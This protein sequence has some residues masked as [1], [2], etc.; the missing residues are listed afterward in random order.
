MI[1]LYKIPNLF[2]DYVGLKHHMQDVEKN[3]K[4]LSIHAWLQFLS[5][6][7]LNKAAIKSFMF[8]VCLEQVRLQ[9]KCQQAPES[10]CKRSHVSCFWLQK[11]TLILLR[12]L[13]WRMTADSVLLVTHS[14]SL[15]IPSGTA[16]W[17]RWWGSMF[18]LT[19]GMPPAHIW[20]AAQGSEVIQVISSD[21][22]S[23][24]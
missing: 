18:L 14:S 10:L 22:Q 7:R 17:H 4:Y 16:P 24:W 11:G 23:V 5:N 8:A 2:L 21:A 1:S 12:L 13:S 9:G 15:P 19:R 6:S 3:N 20:M